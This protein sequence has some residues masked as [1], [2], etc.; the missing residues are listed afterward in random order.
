MHDGKT[1]IF[2]VAGSRISPLPDAGAAIPFRHHA[3]KTAVFGEKN[4]FPY[5]QWF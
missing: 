1:K 2:P 5:I 3:D 4:L